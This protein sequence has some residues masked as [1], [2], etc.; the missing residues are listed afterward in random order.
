MCVKH[1]QRSELFLYRGAAVDAVMSGCP[2]ILTTSLESARSARV[3]IGT[4]PKSLRGAEKA[5]RHEA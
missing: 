1:L 5:Y 4:A 3:R 2:A